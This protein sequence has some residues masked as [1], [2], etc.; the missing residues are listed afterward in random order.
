MAKK[1]FEFET[2]EQLKAANGRRLSGRGSL[3]GRNYKIHTDLLPG[4]Y[5]ITSVLHPTSLRPV[6]KCA[7]FV[8]RRVD[9]PDGR[10]KIIRS[11][12]MSLELASDAIPTN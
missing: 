12:F 2:M 6:G 3:F 10:I 4:G 1:R 5:F 8:V 9:T 7:P 11:G